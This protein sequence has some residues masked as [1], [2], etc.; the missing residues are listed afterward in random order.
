MKVRAK[1]AADQ[2]WVEETLER[3]WG[4]SIVVADGE[5]FEPASLPA[6][7][8]G[9]RLGLLTY[10]AE[11]PRTELVTLN[12]LQPRQGIGSHNPDVRLHAVPAVQMAT[13]PPAARSA[14][15]APTAAALV[16]AAP[17]RVF[18]LPSFPV[19]HA[20]RSTAVTRTR[21]TTVMANL[22]PCE[23]TLPHP[24]RPPKAPLLSAAATR[25]ARFAR[26]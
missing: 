15:A 10:T 1:A 4:G 24:C 9:D 16:A 3:L 8:A 23:V 22:P 7:I 26:P 19:V 12:A 21:A 18:V 13:H 2:P 5:V 11:P 25:V 20:P 6:L 17:P 14:S